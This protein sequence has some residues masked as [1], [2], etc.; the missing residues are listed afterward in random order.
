MRAPLPRVI[1][2]SV[3][4]SDIDVQSGVRLLY[5]GGEVQL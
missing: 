3:I 2:F 1:L 4:G 5:R